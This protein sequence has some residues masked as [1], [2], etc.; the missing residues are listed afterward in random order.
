MEGQLEQKNAYM[1]LF[2]NEDKKMKDTLKEE[3][4]VIYV[5]D[6]VKYDE[7]DRPYCQKAKRESLWD[8]NL[9]P[10]DDAKNI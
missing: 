9:R 1:H 4:E 6:Q 7:V 8:K 3:K 10:R 2:K 5:Y